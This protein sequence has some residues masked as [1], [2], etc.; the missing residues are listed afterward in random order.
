MTDKEVVLERIRRETKGK[1]KFVE[2][3]GMEITDADL[4]YCK[5]EL[6]VEDRHKNPLGTVHGGCLYTMADTVGGLAAASLGMGG[7]T[8]SGNMYFL[9]PALNVEKLVCEARVIKNGK[10]IRV[11]EVNIYGDNGEEIART[12]FEYM[13][14]QRNLVRDN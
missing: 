7:P 3:I 6:K 9:R 11:V 8:L 4:G 10:R 14:P 2:M 12:L 5:G 13:D 1:D